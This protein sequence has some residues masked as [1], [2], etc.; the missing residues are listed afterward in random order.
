MNVLIY[1]HRLEA[2]EHEAY[3]RWLRRVAT[4]AEPF[5][6]SEIAMSGFLRIVTHRKVFKTPTPLDEA[7]DFL[8]EIAGRPTCRLIRPGA[9]HWGIFVELCQGARA[10]DKLVADAY[11][12]AVAVEH[13]CE[14]ITSDSDFARFRG[15]R[16]SHPLGPRD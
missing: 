14:W 16:W 8:T 10:T 5:A 7:L 4:A 11:H 1:A 9:R 12:A 13:G 2:P 6:M 3:A 15:L